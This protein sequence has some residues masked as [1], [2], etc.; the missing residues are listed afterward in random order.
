[1]ADREKIPPIPAPK[2]EERKFDPSVLAPAMFIGAIGAANLAKA[3]RGDLL[4]KLAKAQELETSGAPR[5]AIWSQTGWFKGV[6]GKWRM[7]IDDS[8]ASFNLPAMKPKAY[9]IVGREIIAKTGPMAEVLSHPELYDAYPNLAD[10]PVTQSR[11]EHLGLF[12]G[13]FGDPL[14]SPSLAIN[15]DRPHLEGIRSTGLH[16]AQHAAQSMEGFARGGNAESL[17]DLPNPAHDAYVQ[18]RASD[19]RV[20][21]YE[22]IRVSPEF[23]AEREASNALFKSSGFSDK[24]DA[25][26]N[27]PGD[28]ERNQ[29]QVDALFADW[30]RLEA[31]RFPLRARVDQ[32][33][34]DL[35]ADGIPTAEPPKTVSGHAAYYQLAGETEARNVQKRRDM[36]MPKRMA[37]P[38]WATQDV[39]DDQQIVRF[40]SGVQAS[41]MPPPKPSFGQ[42]RQAIQIGD[43][44][45]YGRNYS[46]GLL[47]FGQEG[48]T[49]EAKAAR[50]DA[51]GYL[52]QQWFRGVSGSHALRDNTMWADNPRDASNFA[53]QIDFLFGQ[54]GDAP[55]QNVMT[56]V[57][58][59][60]P[61]ERID[62]EVLEGLMDGD[63][64]EA[65]LQAVKDRRLGA[66]IFEHPSTG[67]T[68]DLLEVGGPEQFDVRVEANPRTL[69]SP[70]AT[71][72]P[73][74]ANRRDLLA[75]KI[76]L[77]L[78]IAGATYAAL[79]PQPAVASTGDL[80]A[81]IGARRRQSERGTIPRL[82]LGNIAQI[83]PTGATQ[84][85][86]EG[87][88]LGEGVPDILERVPGRVARN[89]ALMPLGI[90]SEGLGMVGRLPGQIAGGVQAMTRPVPASAQKPRET[91]RTGSDR[92]TNRVPPLRYR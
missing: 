59:A 7:E 11:G 34:K 22:R 80:E 71:F 24:I 73:A 50:R 35:R 29:A 67:S 36:S 68:I 52:P 79:Q 83:D 88:D 4:D 92:M 44:L 14:V 66:G 3:G 82:A 69:R 49:A 70:W 90:V 78:G 31:E 91:Y 21:E 64:D 76:L 23:A 53:S 75:S 77:P 28:W 16:E 61:V 55:D 37:L 12:S 19:P 58:R 81:D 9:N 56:A 5:E 6:D 30:Q 89:A 39:P 51:Q 74:R 1:M 18:K 17:S 2:K 26:M 27:E 87:Y 32:L 10:V 57:S 40:G 48:M 84:A 46:L 8:G 13:D 62:D 45:G 63:P 38:P 72:D 47:K 15:L 42:L 86:A 43:D 60:S 41:S 65:A 33:Y 25:L 85:I 20:Q 54:L